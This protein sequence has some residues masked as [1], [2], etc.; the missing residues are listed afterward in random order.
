VTLPRALGR[1]GLTLVELLVAL[2]VTTIAGAA[3]I[4]VMLAQNRA[5]GNNEA[6]R[7]ARAVSRG[8]LNRLLADLRVVEAEGALDA[9]TV[10]GRNITLRVPYAIGVACNTTLPIAATMLPVDNTQWSAAR[11]AGFAWRDNSTSAYRYRTV[12]S[13]GATIFT[14]GTGSVCASAGITTLPASA[15]GGTAGRV[16]NL[17]AGTI[18]TGTPSVGM[19]V[20]VYQQV[21]YR[22]APSSAL[23]GRVALWREV[24]NG[25]PSE[26]LAAPFDSSARFAF[27]VVGSTVAQSALPSP[28]SLTRGVEIHLD[29]MSETAPAGSTD[30]KRVQLTTSI[31]FKNRRD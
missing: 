29:G 19:N 9:L 1:S 15:G 26:E 13:N 4:Q 22:F 2:T 18:G 27:Y 23:P 6:W 20:F 24:L 10:D 3:L 12:S 14:P 17:N 5:S 28:R 7:V 11:F 25:G 16:V 21:R 30:P 8:S 31:F